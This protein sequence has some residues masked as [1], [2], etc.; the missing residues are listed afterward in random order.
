M[1]KRI[2]AA[3]LLFGAFLAAAAA[4]D[5]PS[6]RRG[7]EQNSVAAARRA[8]DEFLAAFNRADAAAWA[9]TLN[10]PHVRIADGQLT[11]WQTP[12]EYQ[13]AFDFDALRQSGWQHSRWDEVR[14]VQAGRDK[15]HFAVRFTRY[16]ADGTRLATY[17]AMYVVTK[18]DG[19]WGVQA[20]SSFA[21]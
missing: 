16:R 7:A 20:R 21:P 17:E 5:G 4:P 15:V 13:A 12:D 8:V 9:Q 6:P 3:V 10:Y 19:H 2:A 1:W 18:Q 11:V 14:A